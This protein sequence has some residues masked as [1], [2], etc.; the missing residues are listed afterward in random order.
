MHTWNLVVVDVHTSL[1]LALWAPG[2]IYRATNQSD[3]V[4]ACGSDLT[5]LVSVSLR[6]F[7]VTDSQVPD[8]CLPLSILQ[9]WHI[10]P[11]CPAASSD[12]SS[13]GYF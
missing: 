3:P 11:E 5:L 13:T 4:R 1:I 8:T 2:H 7:P 12:P 9:Q 10:E 6:L